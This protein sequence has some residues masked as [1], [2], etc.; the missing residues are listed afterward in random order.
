MHFSVFFM[1]VWT[2]VLIPKITST[3]VIKCCTS[4]KFGAKNKRECSTLRKPIYRLCFQITSQPFNLIASFIR[5][6]LSAKHLFSVC[7]L[8]NIFS[9]PTSSLMHQ[10]KDG[11]TETESDSQ[12]SLNIFCTN[13]QNCL[14][15]VAKAFCHCV[16]I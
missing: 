4:L 6:S 13:N 15:A 3:Q 2:A 7:I 16:F 8:S 5:L 14:L 1:A 10:V 12:Q 11:H 9:C